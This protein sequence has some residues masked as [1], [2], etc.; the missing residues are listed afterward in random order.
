[1]SE[2]EGKEPLNAS[3]PEQ[4]GTP[5]KRHHRLLITLIVLAAIIW[6][7]PYLAGTAAGTKWALSLVNSSIKGRVE[8]KELSVSWLGPCRL[9][10][11]GAFDPGNRPVAEVGEA[12]YPH[13]LL[14]AAMS[15]VDLGEIQVQQPHV[16]LYVNKDGTLSLAEAFGARQPSPP[17]PS[18]PIPGIKGKLSLT[19]GTVEVIAA[20]GR[21]YAVRDVDLQCGLQTLDDLT[22]HLACLLQGQGKLA[23]DASIQGLVKDGRIDASGIH[24]HLAVQT[25]AAI[26]LSPVGDLAGL[27]DVK[28]MLTMAIDSNVQGVGGQ[29]GFDISVSKFVAPTSGEAKLEPL[30]LKL[31]GQAEGSMRN[32]SGKVNL[33]GPGC[34]VDMAFDWQQPA[35]GSAGLQPAGGAGGQSASLP[36]ANATV[37][38]KIDLARL[39]AA[40]PGLMNVRPDVKIVRGELLLEKIGLHGGDRPSAAGSVLLKDLTAVKDGNNV[41]WQ[42]ISLV[43]AGTCQDGNGI[44]IDKAE[45]TSSFATI[46][47]SGSTRSGE[48]NVQAD[49]AAMQAELGQVVDLSGFAMTGKI[50]VNVQA[51]RVAAD[52]EKMDIDLAVSAEQVTYRSVAPAAAT[53]PAASAPA[54]AGA[55]SKGQTTAAM[56]PLD[57]K[58]TGH[59]EGSTRNAAGK[60]NLAGAGS[61]VDV[62]FDWQQPAATAAGAC[63]PP[64]NATLDGKIDLARLASAVPG[65]MNVQPGVKIVHGELLLEKI[66]LHGGDRPS[67]AGSVQV[68]DFS[69]VKDGK[70]VSWQPITLVFAGG[71]EDGNGVRID[72]A[73]LTSSFAT[74]HASGTT[75]S[76]D[77]NV[78]VDLAAMQAELGQVLDLGGVALAGK[79]VANVRAKRDAA[80]NQKID[81]ELLANADQV[82][83]RP[84][85]AAG[86]TQPAETSVTLKVQGTAGIRCAPALDVAAQLTFNDVH[87]ALGDK[88]FD[89]KTLT[90]SGNTTME[91]GAQTMDLKVNLN[92]DPHLVGLQLAGKVTDLSATKTL[93][94]SGKYDGAWDQ[95]TN[96]LQILAPSIS[97]DITLAG[98]TG[99]PVKVT[100]PITKPTITPV[101]RG[102]EAGTDVGWGSAKAFGLDLGKAQLQPS[103]NSEQFVLPLAEIPASGGMVRLAAT[104]DL[105]G[106]EP[107]LKLPAKLQV[108]QDV[109]INALFSQ[110]VMGHL[111]PIFT[112]LANVQGEVSAVL[113]GVELPLGE[114]LKKG[115]KGS[116]H[117]DLSKL[118]IQPAGFLSMLLELRGGGANEPLPI[119]ITGVD[120]VIRN[121]GVEYSNFRIIFGDDF[122]L[123]FHGRVGFD[124][125]LEMVV[126]VPITTAMM[127][128][129]KIKG[130]VE[131]FARRLKGTRVD[132]PMT[133]SRKNPGLDL[134]KVNLVPLIEKV[135]G[136][137]LLEQPAKGVGG[138]VGE[139]GKNPATQLAEPVKEPGA[140]LNELEKKPANQGAQPAKEP[141][142]LL[143]E[144]E[145][146]PATTQPATQPAPTAKPTDMLK[147]IEKPKLPLFK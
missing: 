76:G 137:M 81:L 29:S 79:I 53:Q 6:S 40:A 146:K 70:N 35:A 47:A 31:S 73:D 61:E 115:G 1:M 95:I 147:D 80:D 21:R 71:Y 56:E 60:V 111:N 144:L 145:K 138:A 58:L 33:A 139:L 50:G 69:A 16:W 48:A 55:A 78:Q 116:G 133:G 44:R 119:T 103:M 99:G 142:G 92:T 104:V 63:M 100:G 22:M 106:P 65:L 27:H 18:G 46:R 122:D 141:G 45:F 51:K 101:Y 112:N 66:G 82:T 19:G 85:A 86:A 23:V 94:L 83:Y 140:L 9:G 68:K 30:D 97:E 8:V 118:K 84:S 89:Q 91:P 135:A 24:G 102:V 38:G 15:W 5:K 130:P 36:Q 126:S 20:D 37:D 34:Q 107:V 75:R 87:L 54:E 136:N 64:G 127:N 113:E 125:S 77:A 17:K 41:S 132:I 131:D 59:V 143:N 43:F 12:K 10:G 62:V 13:G 74:M 67:A 128:K 117:V 108:L 3:R 26:D 123:I 39:A 14:H 114:G 25:P 96:V 49:L 134:A 93:D 110:K 11:I 7:A 88:R 124:D 90:L 98:T 120:F 129:F 52:N 42:P 105:T 32:L 109:P 121:G 57:L 4:T 28:G 2:T 72:K